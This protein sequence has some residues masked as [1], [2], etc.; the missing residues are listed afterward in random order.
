MGVSY[1]IKLWIKQSYLQQHVILFELSAVLKIMQ[2]SK[3]K[4]LERDSKK[5]NKLGRV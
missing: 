2:F 3:H 1:L 4:K 5:K